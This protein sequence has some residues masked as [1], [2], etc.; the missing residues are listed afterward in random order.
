MMHTFY[1][2]LGCCLVF[3]S[4]LFAQLDLSPPPLTPAVPGQTITINLNLTNPQNALLDAFGF[5]LEY[6]DALLAFDNVVSA[7]TLTDGWIQ[8]SGQESEPGRVIVGAFDLTGTDG[9]GVLLQVQFT[10]NANA[11]SG[12]R[13]TIAL[14]NFSDDLANATTSAG[15]VEIACNPAA[16]AE[17]AIFPVPE[18]GMLGDGIVGFHDEVVCIDIR[19]NGNTSPIGSFGLD[20]HVNPNHLTYVSA[21]GVDLTAGFEQVDGRET[22]PGSGIIRCGGF[23][24]TPVPPNSSGAIIRLCFRVTCAEGDRSEVTISDLVDNVAGLA[25]CCNVFECATCLND[26]DLNGDLQLT[27]NDAL[28]TFQIFLATGV[29]PPECDTPEFECELIA[30]DVNCDD[31]ITPSDALSIFT[32]FLASMPPEHCFA[33]SGLGRRKFDKPIQLSLTQTLSGRTD[34]GFAA[35]TLSV[36]QAQ[37]LEAFGLELSFDSRRWRFTGI[38]RTTATADW[39][40]LAAR[41]MTSGLLKIGGF[42]ERPLRAAAD[43]ELLVLRFERKTPGDGEI[44][45][46]ITKLVDDFHNAAINSQFSDSPQAGSSVP[47]SFRLYQSFPN[48]LTKQSTVLIR[49]DLAGREATPVELSVFNVSGQLVRQLVDDRRAPGSYEVRWD[50]RNQSG[51]IVPAGLYWYRLRTAT[52]TAS[53]KLLL[54]Q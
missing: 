26:G 53:H 32:R 10:V 4:S 27:P 29:L 45:L 49:Y 28:C 23:G 24:T 2:T 40:Q 15:I 6:S 17:A 39:R 51:A 8:V 35:V 12:D 54:I 19:I 47:Q 46:A 36:A 34:A 3:A 48:P 20:V 37:H 9:A 41:E 5:V 11:G 33:Q 52:F 43:T 14:G 42:N 18:G 1:R 16:C 44:D 13:S 31:T 50:G 22:A 30:A 38:A 21:A 7:G 25:P